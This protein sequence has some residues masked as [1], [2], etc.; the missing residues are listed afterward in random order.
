MLAYEDQLAHPA[1]V[2]ETES[3]ESSED[4]EAPS[5]EAE[6]ETPLLGVL[7]HQVLNS[8]SSKSARIRPLTMKKSKQLHPRAQRRLFFHRTYV[9][10]AVDLHEFDPSLVSVAELQRVAEDAVTE[11]EKLV[12]LYSG[13]H[14]EEFGVI[15]ERDLREDLARAEAVV[16]TELWSRPSACRL[17]CPAER[18]DLHQDSEDEEVSEELS[19]YNAP[20]IPE[21]HWR[22]SICLGR[23]AR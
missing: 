11:F 10:A 6:A 3:S 4:Q 20:E 21:G 19:P 9:G 2:A 13:S 15:A 5:E 16:R 7:I 12:R 8:N 22:D 14:W 18:R 1:S 23:P 17:R